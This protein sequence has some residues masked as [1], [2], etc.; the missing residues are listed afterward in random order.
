VFA[1]ALALISVYNSL[2]RIRILKDRSNP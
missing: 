1:L 2:I